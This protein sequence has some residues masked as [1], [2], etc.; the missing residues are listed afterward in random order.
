MDPRLYSDLC[1]HCMMY[2]H[3]CRQNI[4]THEISFQGLERW[5]SSWEHLLHFQRIGA[6]FLGPLLTFLNTRNTWG[7]HT[8]VH[9]THNIKCKGLNKAHYLF[10][11]FVCIERDTC[12]PRCMGSSE[13]TLWELVLSF[14]HMGTRDWTQVVRP[15]SQ[16]FYPRVILPPCCHHWCFILSV[17]LCE[18]GLPRQPRWASNLHRLPSAGMWAARCSLRA[19]VHVAHSSE[20]RSVWCGHLLGTG[21]LS[22][23]PHQM[24]TNSQRPFLQN[25]ISI[26]IW[27]LD[28]Q[29]LDS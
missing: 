2:R 25:T 13:D 12:M 24:L 27:W 29:Y 5:L 19:D 22:S 21:V 8:C 6:Q 15:G 17:C 16:H 10:I 3:I 9:E 4:H 1:G 14:Y 20:V 18:T 7:V 26:G 28:F 23:W 11:Y